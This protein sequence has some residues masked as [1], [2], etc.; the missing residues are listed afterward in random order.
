MEIDTSS[1]LRLLRAL[2]GMS[3]R[4]LAQATGIPLIRL[5]RIENAVSRPRPD[6]VRRLGD[7]LI[8]SEPRIVGGGR[9]DGA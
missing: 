7:A 3:Q 8:T 9:P 6:E 1:I 2:H 4:D 5:W